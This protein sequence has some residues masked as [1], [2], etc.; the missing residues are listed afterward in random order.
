MFYFPCTVFPAKFAAHCGHH[1]RVIVVVI[2]ARRE[3]S[4]ASAMLALNR[5]GKVVAVLA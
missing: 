5:C 3:M 1:I 2:V 4:S